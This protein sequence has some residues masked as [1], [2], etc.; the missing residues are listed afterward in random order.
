[1]SAP[2]IVEGIKDE[3]RVDLYF[4]GE[5]G[6]VRDMTT[7]SVCPMESLL[8]FSLIELSQDYATCAI[9]LI[10]YYSNLLI[11]N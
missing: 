2:P 7:L 5:E 3:Y 4:V 6:A 11:N 9:K 8:R 10:F 1:M